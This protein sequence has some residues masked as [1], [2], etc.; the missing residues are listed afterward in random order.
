MRRS[1]AVARFLAPALGIAVFLLVWQIAV[2]VGN[3]RPFILRSPSDIVAY[4]AKAPS[5]FARAAWITAAHA[6]TGFFLAFVIALAIGAVLSSS[7]FL[8][9]AAQ[10]VL[11]I[12]QVTPFAAY[13]GAIVVW[14]GNGDPPV[15][16][17]TTLVCVPAFVFAAVA[18]LRSADPASREL[19]ESV[20]ASRWQVL[21]RLRLP[22]ALPS[23]FIAA[24]YNVGLALIAAY[25]VEGS[26][27]ADAGLGAIG[28]R[29]AAN[30]LGDPLWATI[31]CMALLGSIALLAIG[32]VE[33]TVLHWHAS[34]R[35]FDTV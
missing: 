4:L 15:R 14:L 29:A 31:F 32:L 3:I 6:G 21:V 25:L 9:R 27:F 20:D 18:G 12:I 35:Q 11:T 22:S 8:E 5:D 26:N 13:I 19:F 33:R 10:P 23:L 34:Q 7:P 17:I 2:K 24:R 28:R 1:Q 30:N 16:F